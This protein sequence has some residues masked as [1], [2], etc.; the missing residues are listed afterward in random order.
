MPEINPLQS[1][2]HDHGDDDDD[3][4]DDDDDG[5]VDDDSI[6]NEQASMET[7]FFSIS[8]QWTVNPA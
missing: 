5:D 3:N 4:D 2:T 8:M 7:P 1:F 6:T